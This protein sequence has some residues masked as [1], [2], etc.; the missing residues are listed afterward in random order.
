[1]HR[2]FETPRA[3]VAESPIWDERER[4]LYFVDIL[5]KCVFR[6]NYRTNEVEKI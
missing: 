6:T 3:M 2:I 1:M 4:V 5:G